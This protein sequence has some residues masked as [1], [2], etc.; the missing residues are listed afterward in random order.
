MKTED[1]FAPLSLPLDMMKENQC[2][3]DRCILQDEDA[4][5]WLYRSSCLAF[6]GSVIAGYPDGRFDM[7]FADHPYFLSKGGVT[8]NAGK[9]VKVDKGNRDKSGGPE[10][11]HV[12]NLAWL[13]SRKI[14]RAATRKERTS[15]MIN[16]RASRAANDR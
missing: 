1:D 10:I 14:H 13:S 7:I 15:H 2:I 9:M 5:I 12:F 16:T 6:M 8:C 3:P 11:N 4:G